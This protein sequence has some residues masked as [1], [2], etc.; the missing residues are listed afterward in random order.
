MNLT[1][2]LSERNAAIL[3]AQARAACM[4]AKDYLSR[5]VARVLDQQRSRN[6]ESR[7]ASCGYG[8]SYSQRN[9]PG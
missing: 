3:E 5:I 2:D 4:P 1:I 7:A 9:D 8:G 6:R